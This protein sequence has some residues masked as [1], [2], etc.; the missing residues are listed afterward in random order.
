MFRVKYCLCSFFMELLKH[1]LLMEPGTA[2]TQ[3]KRPH[4][5]L[6]WPLAEIFFI[7]Q[8]AILK[9]KVYFSH[10]VLNVIVLFR[11]GFRNS[12]KAGTPLRQWTSQKHP[13]S[14]YVRRDKKSVGEDWC[15]KKYK[16]KLC[17]HNN[18]FTFRSFFWA[19]AGGLQDLSITLFSYQYQ[20]WKWFMR[21]YTKHWWKRCFSKNSNTAI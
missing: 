3:L 21:K 13:V 6:P 14:D 5:S 15:G 2:F 19:G 17:W 16:K 8:A 1:F 12:M 4:L 11:L 18:I 9:V 10:A 7:I 20:Q